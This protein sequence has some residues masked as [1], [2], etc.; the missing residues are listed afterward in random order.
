MT[1][2]KTFWWTLN[3]VVWQRMSGLVWALRS[4]RLMYFKVL[5]CSMMCKY[6]PETLKLT[7]PSPEVGETGALKTVPAYRNCVSG[8]PKKQS[9]MVV[10]GGLTTISGRS[11]GYFGKLKRRK[12][13][14]IC[15]LQTTT[16]RSPKQCSSRKLLRAKKHLPEHIYTH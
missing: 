1:K 5:G 11:W 13:R 14:G 2:V 10:N 15:G 6:F 16:F 9:G 8:L 7:K 12:C 4:V 3:C